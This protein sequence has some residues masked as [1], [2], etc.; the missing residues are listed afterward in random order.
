[1]IVLFKSIT[2]RT[3][4]SSSDGLT[5][6]IVDLVDRIGVGAVPVK[7]V[8][9]P[10]ELLGLDGHKEHRLFILL[11]GDNAGVVRR[12]IRRRDE[13]GG[14]D[15]TGRCCRLLQI[16]RVDGESRFGLGHTRTCWMLRHGCCSC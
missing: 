2:L 15:K 1:M 7:T 6:L 8:L 9:I 5:F 13:D 4:A 11:F 10:P 12:R 3:L 16:G 14:H